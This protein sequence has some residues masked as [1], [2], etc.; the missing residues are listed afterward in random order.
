MY[1]PT[2]KSNLL[3]VHDLLFIVSNYSTTGVGFDDV[4]DSYCVVG[5]IFD[6]R[7]ERDFNYGPFKRLTY[8]A[9]DTGID[10]TGE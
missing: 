8:T 9:C 10:P 4:D 7:C 2:S 6:K 3:L 5:F 1:N